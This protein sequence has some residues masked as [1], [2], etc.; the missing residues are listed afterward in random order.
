VSVH[1]GVMTLQEE[2]SKSAIDCFQFSGYTED[3]DSPTRL[4]SAAILLVTAV[5]A[6]PVGIIAMVVIP[7]FLG[8]RAL[9]NVARG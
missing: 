7:F 3:Y 6:V 1:I 8:V 2:T 4:K 9:L 5:I